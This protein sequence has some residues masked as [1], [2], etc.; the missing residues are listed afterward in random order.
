MLNK[1]FF[2]FRSFLLHNAPEMLQ[3]SPYLKIFLSGM[4]HSRESDYFI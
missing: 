1:F 2:E 4:Q 3:I